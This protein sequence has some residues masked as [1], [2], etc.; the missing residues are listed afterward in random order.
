M[1]GLQQGLNG[2]EIR[3]DLV[4]RLG[5]IANGKGGGL[6]QPSIPSARILTHQ[7][8]EPADVPRLMVRGTR[9]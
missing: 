7:L 9:L 8:V 6:P 1:V 4:S 3:R 2:L 5:A